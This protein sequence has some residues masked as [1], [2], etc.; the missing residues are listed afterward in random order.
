VGRIWLM[1]RLFLMGVEAFAMYLLLIFGV[2]I[3]IE[4]RSVIGITGLL[5]LLSEFFFEVFL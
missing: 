2:L 5:I 4:V 3:L 1:A